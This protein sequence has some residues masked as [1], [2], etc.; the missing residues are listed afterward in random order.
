MYNFE[1]GYVIFE[2]FLNELYDK[3]KN[4][5]RLGIAC[6]GGSDSILLLYYAIQYRNKYINKINGLFIIHIIDGHYLIEPLL[7]ESMKQAVVIVESLSSIYNIPLI[8]KSNEDVGIFNEGK[9]IE[10]RCHLLRKSYFQ[11][12]Y[13]KYNLD[14]ILTGHTKTD[15]IEHFFISVIRRASLNRI[16]GMDKVTNIYARPILFMEKKNTS[17]ILDSMFIPYVNDPC[18]DNM[19]YLRNS[20]RASVIPQLNKCDERANDSI[21]FVM[22][23]LKK[24]NQFVDKQVN[25]IMQELDIFS[26]DVFCSLNEIVQYKII[27]MTLYKKK[28]FKT[29]SIAVCNEIIRFL[30]N[31]N[32]NKHIVNGYIIQKQKRKWNIN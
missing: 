19:C 27:E 7:K 32:S 1:S 2:K 25:K 13:I 28:Y 31:S 11:E 16:S 6:S 21:I 24:Q 18:N 9:S 4:L 12:I 29:V 30:C 17:K 10:E 8:I 3:K 14:Y 26:I 23:M 5:L 20:I 22:N 15:Q